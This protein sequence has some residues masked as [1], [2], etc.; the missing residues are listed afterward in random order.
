MLILTLS[1]LEENGLEIKNGKK[2][3]GKSEWAKDR[4]MLFKLFIERASDN[5]CL[6]DSFSIE[7]VQF[8]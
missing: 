8:E 5:Y 2:F 3:P 4:S 7:T 6:C 1:R